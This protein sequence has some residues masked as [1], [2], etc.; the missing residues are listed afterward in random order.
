MGIQEAV[1]G[2]GN[3]SLFVVRKRA[4]RF[5]ASATD[6]IDK[7]SIVRS[8]DVTGI[9]QQLYSEVPCGPLNF[10]AVQQRSPEQACANECGTRGRPPRPRR[11]ALHGPLND[12]WGTAPHP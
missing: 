2:F 7:P 5:Y 1:A 11:P 4:C 3:R 10:D 12:G 8:W 9:L 6:S